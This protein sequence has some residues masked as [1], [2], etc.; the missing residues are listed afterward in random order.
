[1]SSVID[2]EKCPHCGGVMTSE[3]D[4]RTQESYR[5]CRRCGCVENYVIVRDPDNNPVL[6]ENGNVQFR[7]EALPGY[8]CASFHQTN[9]LGVSYPLIAPFEESTL[10]MFLDDANDPHI[11]RDKCYLTRWDPGL[12]DVVAVFGQTPPTYDEEMAE[13]K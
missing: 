6:D 9:G 4:C 13:E 3:F 12:N 5:F 2:Y 7:T 8:G 1:M 10:R 11:E